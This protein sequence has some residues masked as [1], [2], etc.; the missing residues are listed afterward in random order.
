M[1]IP[2]ETRQRILD[3]MRDLG[4]HPNGVARNLANRRT[5][6]IAVVM[7]FP[8]IFSGWSGFTNEMMRGVTD[9]AIALGY[10]ILLHTRRP[11][12]PLQADESDDIVQA[13]V[14]TLTDGRVDGALL[15][16]DVDDPLSEELL[17]R[18]FP[19]VL[20]F[21]RGNDER[22]NFVD[23]D[24]VAGARIAME[25]LLSRGHRRIV[26]LAGSPHSGAAND[27][28]SGYRDALTKA[29]LCIRPDWIIETTFAGADYNVAAGL[30]SLPE[31]ERPTA[32]FA[33][34]D[35]VAIQMVRVLKER[36]FRVPE[37]VSVIGFDSTD[38]C[39]HTDPPLTSVRQPIYSMAV[40]ALTL[41][42]RMI[43]GA[44]TEARPIVIQPELDI[45][46]SCGACRETSS[47]EPAGAY[48]TR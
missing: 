33:W 26:H 20:M 35:E 38:V 19:H 28:C 4:Y 32:V 41:L 6:T 23:C 30:F 18:G 44:E 13:E 3:A 21:T 15:L 5:H 22:Q 47:D 17:K 42:T 29:G 12:E 9:T 34:S 31:D 7:Q 36:G 1:R 25:S 43:E 11:A 24:N 45:R 37:D 27:R 39:D 16:R 10:D 14:A 40:E 48:P 46:R 8:A 2:P